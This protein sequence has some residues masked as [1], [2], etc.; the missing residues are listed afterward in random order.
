M[1]GDHGFGVGVVQAQNPLAGQLA[2]LA[3]VPAPQ[4]PRQQQQQPRPPAQQQQQKPPPQ[5]Q[6]QRMGEDRLLP[7]GGLAGMQAGDLAGGFVGV[8]PA[9]QSQQVPF[10]SLHRT[11]THG[12]AA[13]ISTQNRVWTNVSNVLCR[14]VACLEQCRATTVGSATYLLLHHS[15]CIRVPLIILQVIMIVASMPNHIV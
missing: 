8:G 4:P 15:C 12:V 2:A 9:M 11:H 10:P 5:Q 13:D 3:E 6:Q 14:L 1:R 7:D